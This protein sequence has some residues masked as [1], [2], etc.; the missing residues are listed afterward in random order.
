MGRGFWSADGQMLSAAQYQRGSGVEPD[1]GAGAHQRVVGK[2][3]VHC[4]V[5]HDKDRT[6]ENGVSA[7]GGVLRGTSWNAARFDFL[8]GP[9]TGNGPSRLGMGCL[10]STRVRRMGDVQLK[11][12]RS[13]VGSPG[14]IGGPDWVRVGVTLTDDVGAFERT[15]LGC[16]LAQMSPDAGRPR[17]APGLV[18]IGEDSS[19]PRQWT[20]CWSR[21]HE[22]RHGNA[23]RRQAA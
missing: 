15:Q 1:V 10:A 7:E 21:C 23:D 12:A 18:G 2:A 4:G 20:A 3:G 16:W 22:S 5:R 6:P 11:T 17:A 14:H 13:V 19:W 8:A 9:G